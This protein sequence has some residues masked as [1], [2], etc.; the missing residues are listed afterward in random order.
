MSI[1]HFYLC[2]ILI[3]YFSFPWTE[4]IAS[5]GDPTQSLQT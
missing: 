1:Y 4:E 2:M 5:I 3:P